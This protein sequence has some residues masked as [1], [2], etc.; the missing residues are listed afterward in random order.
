[1]SEKKDFKVGERV[2]GDWFDIG[3]GFRRIKGTFMGL[4]EEKVPI[5][6]C[7]HRGLHCLCAPNSIRRQVKKNRRRLWIHSTS[8]GIYTNPYVYTKQPPTLDD[9][10]EFVEVRKKK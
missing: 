7:D 2:A 9:F 3:H 4:T 5:I 10:V 6:K 1:M 8:I